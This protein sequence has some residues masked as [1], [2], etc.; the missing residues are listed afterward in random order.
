MF[1]LQAEKMWLNYETGDHR[2]IL[3]LNWLNSIDKDDE[4]K[5]ALLGFHAT[6]GSD[7]VSSFFRWRKEKLWKTVEKYSRFTMFSKLGNSWEASE[8][9]LKL[10]EQFACHLYEGK[11]KLVDDL[12]Y[13]KFERVYCIKKRYKI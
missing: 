10:L 7:Y 1:P 8:E 5:L 9:D 3:K 4:N 6:T 13:E 12:R 2:H 11:G